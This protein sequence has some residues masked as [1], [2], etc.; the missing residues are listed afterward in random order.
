M[1]IYFTEILLLGDIPNHFEKSKNNISVMITDKYVKSH[2]QRFVKY[3]GVVYYSD[4]R[5]RN[6]F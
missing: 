5:Y 3:R 6:T 1:V 4:E 2:L